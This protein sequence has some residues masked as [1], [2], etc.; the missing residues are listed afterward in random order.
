MAFNGAGV[1]A[2]PTSTNPVVTG[3]VISSTWANTTLS[4]IATGLSTCI[5]KDGQQIVTAD[6]PFAT[7]KL[8]G[9]APGTLTT[10]AAN[11]SQLQNNGAT[12]LTAVAGTNTITASVSSGPTPSAYAAGQIFSF[13]PANS[14]TG[15]TTINIGSLGAKN[16][17]AYGAALASQDIVANIP[18][19]IEYDGTQFNLLAGGQTGGKGLYRTGVPALTT[20]S[21][22][23][24][25]ITQAWDTTGN[26]TLI[27]IVLTDTHDDPA[28]PGDDPHMQG[29]CIFKA[30]VDGTL[31]I[32]TVVDSRLI[33]QWSDPNDTV[34]G[35]GNDFQGSG[36]GRLADFNATD[37]ANHNCCYGG[38]SA[39]SLTKGYQ[40]TFFGNR[41]GRYTTTGAANTYLGQGAG[42]WA[43][44]A[45][46]NVG[47]GFH[48]GLRNINTSGGNTIV[49]SQ[50]GEGIEVASVGASDYDESVLVGKAAGQ[51]I[52]TASKST[53]VG[54]GAGAYITTGTGNTFIGRSAGWDGITPNTHYATLTGS[55]NIFIGDRVV[56]LTDQDPVTS[57][58]HPVAGAPTSNQIMIGNANN[59][60]FN[61]QGVGLL[62][63]PKVLGFSPVATQADYAYLYVHNASGEFFAGV[64]NSTTGTIIVGNTAYWGAVRA[65][66]GL[67]FSGNNGAS[68]G[69]TLDS[70]NNL[71]LGGS[72]RQ[73][74]ATP[75]SAA[76]AGTAGQIAYDANY[77]YICT[78][79][80]TWKRVAIA[81]W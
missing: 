27:N 53:F 52:E 39:Y 60:Y 14:N 63:T 35:D 7:H 6:I 80:N 5:L 34:F 11:V 66:N 79:A 69:M 28:V 45:Q 26:P 8:T 37:G 59:D 36:C 31:L 73:P 56:A 10:D 33:N 2:L 68:V 57:P 51:L 62:V 81:T 67:A 50:A 76:A 29:A 17:Y 54:W 21:P 78:A 41:S 77:I 32:K 24:I 48:A 74:L 9:V 13:I 4:Q 72:L 23:T 58:S 16:I 3:T 64:E 1:F 30:T 65:A 18:V 12:Y 20:T 71:T 61:V 40:N 46:Y 25:G 38:E 19:Q 44:T 49:G 43:T 75:A 47:V 15:A 55:N 70:S 22:T 42:Y